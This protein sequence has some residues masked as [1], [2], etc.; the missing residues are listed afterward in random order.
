MP[1][2]VSDIAVNDNK[3]FIEHRSFDFIMDIEARD[4][5]PKTLIGHA[6]IFNEYID[7][8]WFQERILPGAFKKSIKNDDVRALFNHDPN[9]VLGRN[10]SGTLTL[11]EDDKGLA[12]NIIPPDTQIAR[13]L[14][15]SIE[16]GDINQMSF[17]FQVMEEAWIKS[18]NDKEPEKRDLIRVKLYDVS[19]V[20]FPAYPTTDVA[21]KSFRS[22]K[23]SHREEPASSWETSLMRKRLDLKLRGGKKYE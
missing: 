23:E 15:V 8:G 11:K 5:K 19:P 9:Y 7:I 2:D 20:T 14:I 4:D 16:R 1:L 21:V 10:K 13:D 6:A 17:A 22:W 3:S 12:I 18:E